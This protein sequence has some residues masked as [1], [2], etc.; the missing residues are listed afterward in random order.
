MN[1]R[2][3]VE[4]KRKAMRWDLTVEWVLVPILCL[5]VMLL[6]GFIDGRPM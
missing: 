4:L 6:C 3:R 2:E 5:T 1:T